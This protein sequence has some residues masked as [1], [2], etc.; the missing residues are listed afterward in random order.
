MTRP[1]T[2][3]DD[4]AALRAKEELAKLEEHADMLG[5]RSHNIYTGREWDDAWPETVTEEARGHWRKHGLEMDYASRRDFA[6]Q[7]LELV[8]GGK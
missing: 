8:K 1:L 7:V 3:A 2:I 4:L 5:R 6:Y